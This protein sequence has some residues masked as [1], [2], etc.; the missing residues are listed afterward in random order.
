MDTL[1]H[2][3]M[4]IHC[5]IHH[6]DSQSYIYRFVELHHRNTERFIHRDTEI[7]R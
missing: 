1:K 3:S 4:E 7:D 6:R 5:K 2:K